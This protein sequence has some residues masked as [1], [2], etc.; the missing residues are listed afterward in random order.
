[1]D[2]IEPSSVGYGAESGS[3]Y[4]YAGPPSLAPGTLSETFSD[5]SGATLTI[6][7]WAIGD[8]TAVPGA[9][10]SSTYPNLGQVSYYFDGTQ[11]GSPDLSSGAWINSSFTY[12]A[13]GS[14]T[15]T[16]QFSNDNSYNGLDNF[17]VTEATSSVPELPTWA[18][19]FLGFVS[20]AAWGLRGRT[21][22]A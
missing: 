22:S 8:D 11:L 13:T 12:V 14:D 17:S 21:A 4:V 16:V 3:Y 15:F 5:I 20:S 10:G 6:S 19:L 2:V 9:D 1:M 7:G 18:L